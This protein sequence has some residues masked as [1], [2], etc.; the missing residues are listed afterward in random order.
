MRYHR[1][2]YPF[3]P[4]SSPL[5]FSHLV[6]SASIPRP[7]AT[8]CSAARVCPS[9]A[10]TDDKARGVEELSGGDSGLFSVS[11]ARRSSEQGHG[12]RC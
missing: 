5:T 7:S 9:P 1:F 11:P 2:Q 10:A 4:N 6:P 3:S 12:G 8:A